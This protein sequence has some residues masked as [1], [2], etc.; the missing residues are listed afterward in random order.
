[1]TTRET[2]GEGHEDATRTVPRRSLTI[3]VRSRT[4][5]TLPVRI[6]R[7]ES[8]APGTVTLTVTEGAA[9]EVVVA[10]A[11]GADVD[12]DGHVDASGTPVVA[13]AVREGDVEVAIETHAGLGRIR[14]SVGRPE[15]ADRDRSGPA[16]VYG[17][18]DD[19]GG[20]VAPN[21]AGGRS[22]VEVDAPAGR[23][24]GGRGRALQGAM[25]RGRR[26]TH[27]HPAAGQSP[28]RYAVVPGGSACADSQC[29]GRGQAADPPRSAPRGSLRAPRVGVHAV[30]A[31][32][33]APA[34]ARAPG[35]RD[36]GGDGAVRSRR[37][38]R[39]GEHRDLLRRRAVAPALA[40][41]SLRRGRER[42]ATGD[43]R[44]RRLGPER[45]AREKRRSPS[46]D[47]ERS[48]AD[49]GA[50]GGRRAGE[51]GLGRCA[52]SLSS[53]PRGEPRRRGLRAHRPEPR[54]A[55]DARS[56]LTPYRLAPLR[57]GRGL[58]P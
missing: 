15:T 41:V 7:S 39:T 31:R 49:S 30:A 55:C 11:P 28:R 46:G 45:S 1:M 13:L 51:R 43:E 18:S 22:S 47:G 17:G 3:G 24:R 42:P 29:S 12:A 38:R 57:R 19:S 32:R 6:V 4:R 35:P 2:L 50:R 33:P 54:G 10:C 56:A 21:R 20:R 37:E 27:A 34:Y 16:A 14:R 25:G 44:S 8:L 53:A 9:G 26:R 23:G 40:V 58:P 48:T 52:R 5:G 36:G